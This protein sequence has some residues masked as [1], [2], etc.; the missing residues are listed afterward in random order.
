MLI[1]NADLEGRRVDLRFDQ[2]INEIALGLTPRTGERILDA[3]GGAVLPG[4]HD[5]HM[6]FLATAAWANGPHAPRIGLVQERK[7]AQFSEDCP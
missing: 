5:H 7:P 6:H 2:Q 1:V 4:L 3:K